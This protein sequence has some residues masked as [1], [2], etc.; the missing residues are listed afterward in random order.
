[1][2][3][4]AALVATVFLSVAGVASADELPF[5]PYEKATVGDWVAFK[6]TIKTTT[7]VG[8]TSQS[9]TNVLEVSKI[10]GDEVTVAGV[11]EGS[12]KVFSRK[13]A[14]T[15]LEYMGSPPS[16]KVD[17]VETKDEKKKVGGKE[18]DCKAVTFRLVGGG[19][20][21][22]TFWFSQD[23]KVTGFVALNATGS[24]EHMEIETLGYGTKEKTLW[25]MTREAA[26]KLVRE[27]GAARD[28]SEKKPPG[29]KAEKAEKPAEK[30]AKKATNPKLANKV[31]VNLREIS[32]QSG[33]ELVL[34]MA[35]ADLKVLFEDGVD[36]KKKVSVDAED[37]S[38]ADVLD[39]VVAQ[40][41][42]VWETKGDT[43]VIKKAGE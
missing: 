34:K 27:A 29:E 32:L 43:I 41:G 1:M 7:G 36:S 31:S 14:P 22:G 2:R 35:G 42:Y 5:N 16:G 24:H 9:A 6:T 13:K 12:V 30:P 26:D 3:I 25:G 23:V 19:E 21:N 4:H 10:N 8:S 40:A 17:K 37:R 20:V 18:F 28:G 33:L 38:V 11:I 15:I 39:G